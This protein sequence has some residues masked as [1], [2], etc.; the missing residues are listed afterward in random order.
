MNQLLCPGRLKIDE[1]ETTVSTSGKLTEVPGITI[2]RTAYRVG[3]TYNKISHIPGGSA[4][5][6]LENTA[7]QG[8]QLDEATLEEA[9]GNLSRL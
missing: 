2:L 8:K 1:P 5:C 9:V 3:P 6:L 4:P 7:H